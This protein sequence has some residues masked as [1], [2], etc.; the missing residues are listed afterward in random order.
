VGTE[1]RGGLGGRDATAQGGAGKK[2]TGSQ[3]RH[4]EKPGKQYVGALP[5]PTPKGDE[6]VR[7]MQKGGRG[8]NLSSW[9]QGNGSSYSSNQ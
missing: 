1:G 9:D 5:E 2:H 6:W 4:G 8:K 3:D 7:R